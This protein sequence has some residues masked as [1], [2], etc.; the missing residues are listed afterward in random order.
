MTAQI[1]NMLLH[2]SYN[3]EREGQTAAEQLVAKQKETVIFMGAG[4]GWQ[5]CSLARLITKSVRECPVKKL[6][7][8]EPDPIH[9][10]GALFYIDWSDVFAVEQLVIALGCP[11]D[12][13]MPLLEGNQINIGNT[14]LN[15]SYVYAIPAFIQHARPYFDSVIALIERNRNKNDI[16]AATYKKFEKFNKS[17]EG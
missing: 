13:L 4:L 14:G 12:S 1:D 10:F 2:S 11:V 7:L 5:F 16:N 8:I 15:A 9:F 6:V 3:P 17:F